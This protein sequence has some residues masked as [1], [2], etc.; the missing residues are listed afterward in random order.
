MSRDRIVASMLPRQSLIEV[1]SK[2][3]PRLNKTQTKVAKVILADPKSAT[4]SS[5]AVLAKKSAVSEPSV[6]RFCKHFNAK[7]FPDLKL[8]LAQSMASGIC[9]AIPKID[10]ADN[11][12]SYTPKIF[13]SA[14]SN[15]VLVRENI[16]HQTVNQVVQSLIQAKR[17]YL[18]GRGDSAVVARDAANK[19]I[20]FNLPVSSHDDIFMQ[21]MLASQANKED[22]FF[23]ISHTA[24]TKEISEVAQIAQKRGSTVI[25]LTSRS[26]SLADFSTINLFVDI[27]ENNGGYRPISSR[28]VHLVI[29]D[30]LMAGIRLRKDRLI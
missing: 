5:I 3:L 14:I 30:V 21:K 9:F 20:R 15:L 25:A 28:I 26:N 23:I 4:E 19:F 1:I 12:T 22:V 17:I 29:L 13:D 11:V 10:P 24:Q 6:N 7:G 8:K 16:C 2:E 27:A 18:F